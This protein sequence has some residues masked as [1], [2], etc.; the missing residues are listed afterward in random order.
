MDIENNNIFTKDEQIDTP[1]DKEEVAQN[2]ENNDELKEAI[3]KQLE[4][5]RRQNMLLGFQVACNAVVEKIE[6]FNHAQGKK[7]NN[8]YK[9]LV[10]DI[11]KFAQTGLSRKVNT[12]GETEP[13]TT[14]N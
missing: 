4:K 3:E 1:A 9:R 12:D 7:S 5:I 11:Q 6:V 2:P 10:K 13:K 8:D 14:Q